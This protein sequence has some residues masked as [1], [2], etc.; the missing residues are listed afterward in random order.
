MIAKYAI[1]APISE[2][3]QTFSEN[4]A[5]PAVWNRTS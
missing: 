3:A 1:A 2:L 5:L 4:T